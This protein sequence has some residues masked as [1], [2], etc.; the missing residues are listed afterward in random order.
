M[1]HRM[2]AGGDR[3]EDA[4]NDEVATDGIWLLYMTYGCYKYV[5]II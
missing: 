3:D 4:S 5:A 2:S 1:K